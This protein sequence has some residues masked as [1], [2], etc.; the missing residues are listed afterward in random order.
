MNSNEFILGHAADQSIQLF[1]Q[2]EDSTQI[3][4]TNKKSGK[5][6]SHR[7]FW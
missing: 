4:I 5:E 1:I 6:K 2:A 7:N 3:N